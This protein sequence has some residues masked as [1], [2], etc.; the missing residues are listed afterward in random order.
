MK[1]LPGFVLV[2]EGPASVSGYPAYRIAGSYDFEAAKAA[3]A[4]ETIVITGSGGLYVLQLDATSNNRE[5]QILVDGL[6]QIVDR[7][8]SSTELAGPTPRVAGS[9]PR[10]RRERKS[11][12]AHAA[13]SSVRRR[14]SNHMTSTVRP[15]VRLLA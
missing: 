13:R 2:G 12:Y 14:F 11:I 8:T 5:A 10:R 9:A 7:W 6:A 3:A 1:N 4:Q 15:I